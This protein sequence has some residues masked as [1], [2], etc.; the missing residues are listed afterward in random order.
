MDVIFNQGDPGGSYYV[1]IKGDVSIRVKY[2]GRTNFVTVQ[3]C[4]AGQQ[5][6]ELRH[7]TSYHNHNK[8][9]Q[10]STPKSPKVASPSNRNTRATSPSPGPSSTSTWSDRDEFMLP[11]RKA[12]ARCDRP[13]EV[14]ML[15]PTMHNI[16][17][18]QPWLI[19]DR[20]DTLKSCT[21]FASWLP[22][23]LAELSTIA[24]VLGFRAGQTIL[25]SGEPVSHLYVVRKGI[26]R[27]TMEVD[28]SPSSSS[29]TSAVGLRKGGRKAD[30]AGNITG[31][32]PR[33]T[34]DSL[35]A[36]NDVLRRTRKSAKDKAAQFRLQRARE[37]GTA[38]SVGV[39]ILTV[40]IRRRNTHLRKPQLDE[41]EGQKD[42]RNFGRGGGRLLYCPI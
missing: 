29:S 28:S 26:A 4:T 5:F 15:R 6:G 25:R 40:R 10:R 11:P 33:E 23:R 34:R 17:H 14:L 41:C 16:T 2:P 3:R 7:C 8:T 42:S 38:R 30:H 24:A 22:E 1:I 36:L 18:C 20:L 12:T 35:W 31:Q 32:V 37:K 39:G 21:V 19:A 27:V 9:G 13:T